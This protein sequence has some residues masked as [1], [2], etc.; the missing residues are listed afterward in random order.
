MRWNGM[1]WDGMGWDG[2]GWD[3]MGW[4]GMGWD[5][6][7]WDGMGWDGMD[8]DGMGMG[9]DGWI[10]WGL[11][12]RGWLGWD[13]IYLFIRWVCMDRVGIGIGYWF[14]KDLRKYLFGWLVVRSGSGVLTGQLQKRTRWNSLRIETGNGHAIAQYSGPGH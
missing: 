7:G 10:G 13:F 8:W 3:G 2:M 11:L 12:S 6:M 14:L 4:I 5:G 1:G 9:L